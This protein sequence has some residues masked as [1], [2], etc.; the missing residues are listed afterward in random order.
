MCARAKEAREKHCVFVFS[1]YFSLGSRNQTQVTGLSTGICTIQA[2]S[3]GPATQFKT[4]LVKHKATFHTEEKH[5]CV[6]EFVG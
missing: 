5:M 1:F 4:M 2:I 6:F 3:T